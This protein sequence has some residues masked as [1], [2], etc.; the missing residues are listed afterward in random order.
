MLT[1]RFADELRS[2]PPDIPLLEA[3]ASHT[4]GKMAPRVHEVFGSH[5][6]SGRQSRALWPWL[7]ALALVLYLAEI[8]GRRAPVAWRWLGA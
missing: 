3:I 7:A 4:G 1:P 2:R 6:D 5:G 8:F